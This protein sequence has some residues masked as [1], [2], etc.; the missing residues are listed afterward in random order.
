M[1]ELYTTSLYSDASLISYWRLEGDGTNSIN[2]SYNGTSNNLSYGTSYGEYGQGAYFNGSNSSLTFNTLPTNVL[3]LTIV[4]WIKP[5]SGGSHGGRV[6]SLWNG[7]GILSAWDITNNYFSVYFTAGSAYTVLSPTFSANNWH[8]VAFVYDGSSKTAYCYADGVKGT[9]VGNA[10]NNI[11]QGGSHRLGIA[12]NNDSNQCFPGSMDDVAVFTR[13]LTQTEIN[14]LYQNA[15]TP[16][17]NDSLTM[18]E[19]TSIA[20]THIVKVENPFEAKLIIY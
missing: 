9:E 3:N 8:H 12:D 10:G 18:T 2:T 13:V 20:Q 7:S 11:E 4:A 16:S 17:V 19:S 1:A 15:L 14:L 5:V 6:V